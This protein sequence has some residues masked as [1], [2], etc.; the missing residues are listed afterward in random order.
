MSKLVIHG[1]FNTR[2][3]RVIWAALELGLDFDHNPIH[4]SDGSAQTP[5]FLA[6]NP[7]GTLPTI[8]DGELCLW[9]SLAI[10][11]YLANKHGGDLAPKDA[12]ETGLA[13]QWS[14]WA[15][16]EVEETALDALKHRLLLPEAD[17]DEA[18]L[19]VAE[20][21]LAKPLSVLNDALAGRDYLFGG[22]F[23]VA[24]LNVAAVVGWAK[25]ARLDLSAW[26]NLTAWLDRC[27]GRPTFKKARGG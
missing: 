14:F 26:P 8:Q 13:L 15:A 10:N 11:L 18:A 19:A 7:N 25:F 3:S 16:T 9:E 27:L 21:K 6:I 2:T 17:R 5:E 4:Y 1:A 23:T 24:D 20:A 12:A 22:R